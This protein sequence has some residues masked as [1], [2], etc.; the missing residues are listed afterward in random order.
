[1]GGVH[2][3]SVQ[4][5]RD[6]GVSVRILTKPTATCL[7]PAHAA[8]GVRRVWASGNVSIVVFV[9]KERRAHGTM[10]LCSGCDR[11]SCVC[12][13][14][15]FWGGIHNPLWQVLESCGYLFALCCSIKARFYSPQLIF[16]ITKICAKNAPPFLTT[17]SVFMD[18]WKVR[19]SS[20]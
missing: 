8:S 10:Y 4:H 14:V 20:H 6:H 18:S 1:M 17:R 11:T 3:I 2:T 5:L 13:C 12:A 9:R 15:F 16:S 19:P 7:G